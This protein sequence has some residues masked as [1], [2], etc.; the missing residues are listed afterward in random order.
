MSGWR[1]GRADG[2]HCRALSSLSSEPRWPPTAFP[3]F[4]QLLDIVPVIWL[5]QGFEGCNLSQ[6]TPH[7]FVIWLGSRP[8]SRSLLC[9]A[10]P[11]DLKPLWFILPGRPRS[12]GMPEGESVSPCWKSDRGKPTS[13]YVSWCHAVSRFPSLTALVIPSSSRASNPHLST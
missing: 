3:F 5:N 4:P 6:R 7:E 10:L 11:N 1:R 8:D 12:T 13:F 9:G 2:R